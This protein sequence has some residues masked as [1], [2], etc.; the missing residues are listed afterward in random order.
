MTNAAAHSHHS[1]RSMRRKFVRR[2][3]VLANSGSPAVFGLCCGND[4][5]LAAAA[6][7]NPPVFS[8]A[9]SGA[10]RRSLIPLF[11]S[12]TKLAKQP[13]FSSPTSDVR[14]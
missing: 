8:V 14:R 13:L 10:L 2:T 11:C 7:R 5:S 3:L 12:C 4:Q 1:R 9:D 6:P